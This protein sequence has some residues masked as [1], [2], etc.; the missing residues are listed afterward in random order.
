M[1]EEEKIGAIL[2]LGRLFG[3]KPKDPKKK[4]GGII[5]FL[6]LEKFW[7]SLL[8]EEREFIKECYASSL[9]GLNSKHLDNPKVEASTTQS[10]SGFLSNYAVWAISKKKYELAD[11]LLEEALRTNK[12][13]V[14]LHFTYN[15]LIDLCYKRRNEGPE[16]IERCI[17]YCME[18]IIKFPEFKEE[19]LKEEKDRFIK[20][21]NNPLYNKS[22]RKR[23]LKKAE[24][25]TFNLFVPSFQRLVIIYENQG[26]YKE[27]IEICN[28]AL[29]Y[30]LIDKTKNGFKGRIEKL[31]KKA[32][33]IKSGE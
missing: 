2:V 13:Q 8:P 18:D 6:K 3:K 23:I 10:D 31:K 16:W 25:V 5:A 28:L 19:Y 17:K 24:S 14:D 9:G 30:G 15:S 27:A 32:S 7:E 4:Y 20:Q 1:E 29:S 26:R 21:A 12:N 22:E 11:K 33:K